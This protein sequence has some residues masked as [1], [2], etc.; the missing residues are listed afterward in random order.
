MARAEFQQLYTAAGKA[1]EGQPWENAYPRPQL[2]RDSFLKLN[3][4]WDFTVSASD[5][6]PTEYPE[7]IRVPFPPQSLLS[8]IRRDIPE[9]QYL[10][11]R[12]TFSRPEGAGRLL[13]HIGAADQ[14]AHVFLNGNPLG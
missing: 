8:G 10:F 2:Q 5:A 4:W 1:S 3:G 14:I 6:L 11:Y 7:R 12:T 13:L 9:G